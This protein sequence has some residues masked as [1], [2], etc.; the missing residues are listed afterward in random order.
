MKTKLFALAGMIAAPLLWAPAAQAQDYCREYQRSITVGG[1]VQNG[2]GTACYMPDGSWK[3]VNLEGPQQAQYAVREQIFNDFGQSAP[4]VVVVNNPRPVV[5]YQPR[6]VYRPTPVYSSFYF[7]FGNRDR[8]DRWDRRDRWD[9]DRHDNR[10]G[11]GHG[12]H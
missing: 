3:I 9:H 8:H 10:R 1:Y 4:P 7:G 12:H 2:Y 6:P 11:R 5:Y